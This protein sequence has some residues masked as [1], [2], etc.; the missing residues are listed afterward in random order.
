M[1][2]ILK[3]ER[4]KLHLIKVHTDSIMHERS[5]TV[6][7]KEKL[8]REFLK[9]EGGYSRISRSTL[10]GLER[11][12]GPRNFDLFRDVVESFWFLQMAVPPLRTRH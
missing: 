3:A 2:S 9:E 10:K 5:L 8:I 6:D 11:L 7:E 12:L 4:N 1:D